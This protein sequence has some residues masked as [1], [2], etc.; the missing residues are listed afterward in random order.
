MQRFRL[1]DFTPGDRALI[2]VLTERAAGDHALTT[3]LGAMFR[4]LAR[5]YYWT[6]SYWSRMGS[7]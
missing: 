5:N 7:D 2:D 6:G 4:A 1:S 3:A